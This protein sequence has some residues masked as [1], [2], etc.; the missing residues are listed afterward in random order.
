[1]PT[2][3]DLVRRSRSIRRFKED[4]P[5]P[6][7]TLWA[8]ADLG[9]LSPCGGNQQP[10]K[11]I[12]S[13]YP[14]LNAQI[15]ES[16]TWASALTDWDGPVEGERPT[17][18]IVILCDTRISTSI[19]CDHGI[20]AQSIMLGA[21]E[22]GFGGCILGAVRRDVLRDVLNIPE[23]YTIQLVLALGVPAETVVIDEVGEDGGTAYWRAPDGTHHVPK[24]TLD[25]VIVEFMP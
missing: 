1:M 20:A 23:R 21:A 14:D 13:S 24:R 8:L 4:Q 10:L 9:R 7:E 3:A 12:I 15:F 25:Q 5:I 22:R 11:Y 2:I 18:Y 6:R 19:G 17:G 16:L